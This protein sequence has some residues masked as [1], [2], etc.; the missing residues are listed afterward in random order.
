MFVVGT[1]TIG[2]FLSNK[3]RKVYGVEIVPEAVKDAIKNANTNNI[4][5]V[6]FRAA[7]FLEGRKNNEHRNL[8][9][10]IRF[11]HIEPRFPF[12]LEISCIN[13]SNLGVS[14]NAP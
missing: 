4:T 12:T 9:S 5:N 11:R 3:C 6:D 14:P 13:Q 7:I 8:F 1:G 2:L 10:F